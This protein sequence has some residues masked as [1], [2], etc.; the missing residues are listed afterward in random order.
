MT[1]LKSEK[2][3]VRK[4]IRELL[5]ALSAEQRQD[6]STR[7]TQRILEL[8]EYKQARVIMVFLSFS[9]EYDTDPLII[10]G[11]STGKIVC[12]PKVDW[13][14]WKMEPV[15][16]QSPNDVVKDV[17]GLREPTGD[18]KIEVDRIDLVL[19]PGIAFDPYGHRVGRGGGF[20]DAFLSRTDL[21]A[22][23]LAPTFDFQ[24][25][26]AVPFDR[27]DQPVNLLL[28]PTKTLYFAQTSLAL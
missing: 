9:K 7:V 20:Y 13:R 26:P 21:R 1:D 22:V 4:D 24:I 6:W 16:L 3:Q 23:K 12:A 17:H 28:T 14:T 2:A 15:K 25:R 27:H 11:L 10:H 18:E 5:H 8:P 19:V